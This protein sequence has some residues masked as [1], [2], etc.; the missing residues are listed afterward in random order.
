[1]PV[2]MWPGPTAAISWPRD[3]PDM[4]TVA[5]DMTGLR[6]S[7]WAF[8]TGS[9][10]HLA[11]A[12]TRRR[13]L[14]R[15][16]DSGFTH[17]DTSPYYGYGLAEHD[18]GRFMGGRRASCTVATK[19]G[20]YAFGWSSS[21]A[22]GVWGRKG[23]GKFMNRIAA[24]SI[25]WSIRQARLSLDQS[26][27]RLRTDHVD[28]LFLHEPDPLLISADEFL[29][30][31]EQERDRGRVRYFGLAG[32]VDSMHPW[33]QQKQGLGHVLQVRDTLGRRQADGITR[34]GRELQFTYGY[35]SG[36]AAVVDRSSIRDHLRAVL[37]RNQRGSVI[38]STR[39]CDRLRDFADA[40]GC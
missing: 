4:E 31:L 15:A 25:D 24:P 13:L 10:H 38:V 34:L 8:G 39:R 20:L 19:V 7:R 22:L 3:R 27:G 5:I 16:A 9:L 28:V 14:D 35:L 18:L 29:R 33:I 17:F 40:A 6:V 26:L 2:S 32:D 21:N 36:S 12:S 11:L 30:W 37:A 23:L 1:M